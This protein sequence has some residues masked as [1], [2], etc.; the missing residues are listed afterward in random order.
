MDDPC[1]DWTKNV[2]KLRPSDGAVAQA[3]PC[4]AVPLA[5]GRK[6]YP[7]PAPRRSDGP[8]PLPYA[9]DPGLAI[10]NRANKRKM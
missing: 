10:L 9:P 1:D 3:L 5:V 6:P 2:G 4:P 7:A 8:E